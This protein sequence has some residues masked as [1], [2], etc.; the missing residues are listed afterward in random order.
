MQRKE[1]PMTLDQAIEKSEDRKIKHRKMNGDSTT[2]EP[3]HTKEKDGKERT[4]PQMDTDAH[5]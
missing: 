1:P 2:K 3:K 5:R 4:E